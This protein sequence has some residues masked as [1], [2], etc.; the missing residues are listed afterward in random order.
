MGRRE[1]W[2]SRDDVMCCGESRR[3]TPPCHP[4]GI[5]TMAQ[6]PQQRSSLRISHARC[7][8]ETLEIRGRGRC[9]KTGRGDS[10]GC[11]MSKHAPSILRWDQ[12]R[13]PI[14][15]LAH[16]PSPLLFTSVFSSYVF[17]HR[18]PFPAASTFLLFAVR[19]PCFPTLHSKCVVTSALRHSLA[20]TLRRPVLRVLFF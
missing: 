8:G 14:S 5:C 20:T 15:Q 6:R 13:C 2:V 16:P 17:R 11:D 3:F 19:P 9:G 12:F 7:R 18:R 4:C 10:A 1:R